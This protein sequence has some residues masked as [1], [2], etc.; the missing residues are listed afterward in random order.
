MQYIASGSGGGWGSRL[1]CEGQGREGRLGGGQVVVRWPLDSS[2][3][4]GG[5]LKGCCTW[6]VYGANSSVDL[7]VL[8]WLL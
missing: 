5:R 1:G 4:S 6:V 8:L 2:T 7:R 3:S